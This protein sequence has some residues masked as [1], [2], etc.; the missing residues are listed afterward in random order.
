MTDTTPPTL[1]VPASFTLDAPGCGVTHSA[2]A[3]DLVAG[4]IAPPCAPVAG[5]VVSLGV[6]NV[7]CVATDT[8]GNAGTA[9]FTVNVRASG[10]CHL[11]A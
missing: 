4:A 10:R 3:S 7:T 1:T 2:S 11:R 5:S 9:T 8:A 6:T